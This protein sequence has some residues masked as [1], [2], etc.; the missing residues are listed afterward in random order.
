M[1]SSLY[2]KLTQWKMVHWYKRTEHGI[3]SETTVHGPMIWKLE[4]PREIDN[5]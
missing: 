1:T 3:H 2:N 4:G 5:V